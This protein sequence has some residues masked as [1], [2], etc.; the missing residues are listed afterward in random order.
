ME[1]TSSVPFS[2]EAALFPTATGRRLT[3]FQFRKPPWPPLCRWILHVRIANASAATVAAPVIAPRIIP[4][5]SPGETGLS[6]GELA[7]L[8]VG[9]VGVVATG[10]VVVAEKGGNRSAPGS[11][12]R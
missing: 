7:G 8:G 2:P 3:S 11:C 4:P 10:G 9:V 5:S 6:A 1:L 12:L